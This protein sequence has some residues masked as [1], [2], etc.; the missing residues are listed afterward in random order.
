MSRLA[1]HYNELSERV[2][3]ILSSNLRQPCPIGRE[4]LLT[5]NCQLAIA[6]ANNWNADRLI[7]IVW[8]SD[9]LTSS[10]SSAAQSLMAQ[11]PS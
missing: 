6:S 4:Q 10:A 2:E 1:S 8:I 11:R 7:L 3:Q 9:L 5:G